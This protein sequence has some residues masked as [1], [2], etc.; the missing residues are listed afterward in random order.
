MM[1]VQ[2]EKTEFFEAVRRTVAATDVAAAE[3]P[4]P[5]EGVRPPA[6]QRQ[7]RGPR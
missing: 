7:V 3:A 5:A 2:Q 1:Q 4:R 6:G